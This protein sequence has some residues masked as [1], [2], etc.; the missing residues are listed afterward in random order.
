MTPSLLVRHFEFIRTTEKDL[1]H[2]QNVFK[3]FEIVELGLVKENE[4]VISEYRRR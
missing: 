4:I 1:H 3:P 2:F